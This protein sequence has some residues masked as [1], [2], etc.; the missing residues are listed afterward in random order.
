MPKERDFEKPKIF[1][2]HVCVWW[3]SYK[4]ILH[5]IRHTLMTGNKTMSLLAAALAWAVALAGHMTS[6]PRSILRAKTKSLHS[7]TPPLYS[8]EK[9]MYFFSETR[10]LSRHFLKKVFFASK[11]FQTVVRMSKFSKS[12]NRRKMAVYWDPPAPPFSLLNTTL[13]SV[14][15]CRWYTF[16]NEIFH[17]FFSSETRLLHYK[18][19]FLLFFKFIFKHGLNQLQRKIFSP[20]GTF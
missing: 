10:P 8:K 17:V 20:L 12:N 14:T 1:R 5:L 18:L 13:R 4:K 11:K 19:R 15:F 6:I 16:F 7:L 2:T 3:I 9:I